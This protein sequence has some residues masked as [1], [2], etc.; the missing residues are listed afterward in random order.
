MVNEDFACPGNTDARGGL[1]MSCHETNS[2]RLS[3]VRSTTAGAWG[4]REA[5]RRQC[6]GRRIWGTMMSASI[7][8]L[9]LGVFALLARED[10]APARRANT[11]SSSL[12]IDADF[13]VPQTRQCVGR[14]TWVPMTSAS[15]WGLVGY[16]LGKST[17]AWT[18][19]AG[20]FAADGPVAISAQGDTG[21]V[22]AV[23]AVNSA[24]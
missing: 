23:A 7:G 18:A 5:V 9:L 22:E 14:R 16:V 20:G 10:I 4:R 11:A 21:P 13:I 17:I 8:R 15:I 3:L 2:I 19:S 1:S 24:R 12:P 6:V